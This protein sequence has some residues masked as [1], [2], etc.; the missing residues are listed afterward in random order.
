MIERFPDRPQDNLYAVPIARIEKRPDP[1]TYN[2]KQ[3]KSDWEK[4]TEFMTMLKSGKCIK[5]HQ[6]RN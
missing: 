3:I 6:K 4:K 5:W 1:I 2:P